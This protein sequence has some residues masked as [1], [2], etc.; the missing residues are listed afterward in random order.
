MTITDTTGE[1]VADDPA[2][3]AEAAG[4]RYV[5]TDE[6]GLRRRRCGR[7]F[8]YLT[9]TG[10][11]VAN[12]ERARIEQLV[13]P[14]AW[15]DVWICPDPDGHLQAVGVDDRDRRQ[16]LYHPRWR[17]YR[18]EA[19]FD[20]LVEFGRSLPAIRRRVEGDLRR[21]DLDRRRVV[22]A[23]VRLIDETLI[24][25]GNEQ[26]AAD[27]E[28][29]GATTLE[30]RHV[31]RIRGAYRVSFTGKSDTERTVETTDAGV[32]AVI[33]A[34]LDRP[35]PQLFWFDAGR[36]VDVTAA[37]VNDYL[38]ADT[39]GVATAKTFRTWGATALAVDHLATLHEPASD[40]ELQ[41]VTLEA[42]DRAADALGNTRVVCRSCYV[43]PIVID[44][45]ESGE[46]A[47]AWA[48]SRS[49]R[50]R[51]RAESATEKILSAAA[52]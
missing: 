3:M 5:S 27:N 38:A 35:Q 42:I 39:C 25:V 28:T 12:G 24:R 13:I 32:L 6:P 36:P 31:E 51:T 8:T 48:A 29:F 14:P 22:A 11:I 9:P 20:L 7:G 45:L 44:A 2:S 19:K 34:C 23:V 50:W 17:E 52:D 10:R 15:R 46:L 49:S 47:A 26:Y 37:H 18:D 16:Y 4:L 21:P 33:D 1:G 41:S 30:P 40:T 43:A